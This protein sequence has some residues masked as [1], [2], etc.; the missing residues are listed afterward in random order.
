MSL[1]ERKL[2]LT[3]VT[4]LLTDNAFAY[5]VSV[6]QENKEFQKLIESYGK[7]PTQRDGKVAGRF[8]TTVE[9][10]I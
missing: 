5:G 4:L 10:S 1:M 6:G 7:V 9:I 2:A 3:L 8:K